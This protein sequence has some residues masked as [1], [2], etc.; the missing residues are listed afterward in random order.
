MNIN[1]ENYELDNINH[2]N[3]LIERVPDI[4]GL[5]VTIPHKENVIKFQNG[6][7]K[8]YNTDHLGFK[9]SLLKWIP[10]RNFSALILGSG[11]SS[12]AIQFCLNK[13]EIP[14]KIVS[15]NS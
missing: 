8:G 6:R 1:Y 9:E 11:G 5:N 10:N 13:L 7:L 2:L 4:N 12:N 15:R 3:N 14:F